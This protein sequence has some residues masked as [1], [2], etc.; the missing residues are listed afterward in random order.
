MVTLTEDMI[1]LYGLEGAMAGEMATP[2]DMAI[3][4]MGKVTPTTAPASDTMLRPKIRPDLSTSSTVPT[5]PA[6]VTPTA[7]AAPAASVDP[8]SSLNDFQR[9]MLRFAAIKDAGMALQGKEGNAVAS[10]MGD[11]TKRDDMARKAAAVQATSAANAALMQQA[12]GGSS[13]MSMSG[14][15]PQALRAQIDTLSQLAFSNP[16]MAPAISARIKV[17]QA[18]AERLTEANKEISNSEMMLTNIDNLLADPALGQALGIEGF[19]RK[20][21]AELGLDTETGRVKARLDQIK[22]SVFLQAFERLKGGGQITELEGTKAEQAM[23]RLSTAVKEED[24]REA[25]RELRFYTEQGIR[26]L[27]GEEIPESFYEDSKTTSDPL[28][29]R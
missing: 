18:E 1:K 8:Y 13:G 2:E 22:G 19:L 14:A 6:P 10:V 20:P 7:T 16:T 5:V 17:L 24:F 3:M 28:G 26:R 11:I 27:K 9:R 23:A 4:G 25:L 29:I 15:T 21:L 12:F